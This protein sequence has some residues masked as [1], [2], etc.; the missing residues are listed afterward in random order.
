MNLRKY[1]TQKKK[2][3]ETTADNI[4]LDELAEAM[5]EILAEEPDELSKLTAERDEWKDKYL[6]S[7]AEFENFRRR[8]N[9]EKSDWIKRS[10]ERLSLE[11]CDVMD[12]FERALAHI[13]PEQNADPL[14]KGILLIEQ[15]LRKVLENQGIKKIEAL[16]TEFDPELHD[17]L[18][19]IPS[20]LEE[21][22]VAAIIQNGYTMHDKVIRPV[23]VA[24][25]NGAE[26]VP[27]T[28]TINEE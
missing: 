21:N 14:I 12:N 27:V 20:E 17:A 9:Q 5:E 8:S 3:T 26:L 16:G 11:I 6:R 28:E 4:N 23:K 13:E 7:M 15:Q 25:S 19:H 18:A 2:E 22:K 10:T 24:V 1:M